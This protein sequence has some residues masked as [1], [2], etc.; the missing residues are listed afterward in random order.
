MKSRL[1]FKVNH[2]SCILLLVSIILIEG[3]YW[4][5][6]SFVVRDSI[7]YLMWGSAVILVVFAAKGKIRINSLLVY[8][9]LYSIMILFNNQ[10]LLHGNYLNTLRLLLSI[11]LLFV[12]ANSGGWIEYV[13]HLAIGIGIANVLATICFFINSNLYEKFILLTYGRYQSGTVNGLYGYR[14]ALADHYSQNGTYITIVLITLA[15]ILFCTGMKKKYR[16][17]V[18]FLFIFV[19]IALLLTSKRAHLMFGVATLIVTYY[20]ANPAEKTKRTFKIM[21]IATFALII[22]ALLVDYIPQLSN[23]FYRIQNLGRDYESLTRI[24]MWEHAIEMFKR[25]PLIGNGWYAFRYSTFGNSDLTGAIQSGCHN[26]YLELLSECGIIGIGVFIT[27]AIVSL[28]STLKNMIIAENVFKYKRALT[29]AFAIQVFVL[30]YGLSGNPIYDRTF[31][32]YVIAIATNI[33]FSENKISLIKN[34]ENGNEE[35]CDYNISFCK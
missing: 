20:A 22:G 9:I 21:I 11:V 15:A 18:L 2:R 29:M 10:E 27:V 25:H 17:F 8:W 16:N 24:S 6:L 3:N 13:P 7:R 19:V 23:T 4:S 14:A 34:R 5:L 30:L 28:V 26:I 32:F 33:A 12:C 1:S 31:N 35:N